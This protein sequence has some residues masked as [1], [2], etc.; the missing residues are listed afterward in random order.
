MIRKKFSKLPNGSFLWFLEALT[1][2]F[3][4]RRLFSTQRTWLIRYVEAGMLRGSLRFRA[5]ERG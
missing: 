5:S 1:W 4:L 3:D 2:G